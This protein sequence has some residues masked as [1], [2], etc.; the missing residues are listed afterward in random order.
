MLAVLFLSP[1]ATAVSTDGLLVASIKCVCM[2][3]CHRLLLPMP[4]PSLQVD[5]YFLLQKKNIVC[6]VL[7]ASRDKIKH[8]G[9]R[10]CNIWPC[11]SSSPNVLAMLQP[12]CYASCQRTWNCH[13]L[14]DSHCCHHHLQAQIDILSILDIVFEAAAINLWMTNWFPENNQCHDRIIVAE[15][16]ATQQL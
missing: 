8:S 6:F 10:W 15:R 13:W 4:L 1:I 5:C 16:S 7:T 12:S 11:S 2:S 3:Y 14:G 9:R